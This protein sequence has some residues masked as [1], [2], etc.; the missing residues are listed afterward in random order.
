MD[1]TFHFIGWNNTVDPKTG[2]KHDKVWAAFE[3]EG[4]HYAVWGARGKRLSFKN[5][6]QPRSWDNGIPS[7]LRTV[8]EQKK[9]ARSADKL[10]KE[11]DSFLLF[12]LFPDFE[13]KVQLELL[14]KTLSNKVM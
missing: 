10:Y 2:S 8:M 7:T 13:E 12:S 14:M 9:S 6:G 11:V 4:T 5:H 1:I 3:L